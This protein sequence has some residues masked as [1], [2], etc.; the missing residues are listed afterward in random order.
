M[1]NYQKL[2]K[3]FVCVALQPFLDLSGRIC[4]MEWKTCD[5]RNGRWVHCYCF[6]A[7]QIAPSCRLWR[8]KL[9]LN[10]RVGEIVFRLYITSASLS[11]NEYNHIRRHYLFIKTLATYFDPTLGLLQA[12]GRQVIMCCVYIGFPIY[13]QHQWLSL[14]QAWE[15]H[16]VWVEIFS[17]F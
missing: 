8:S 3:I 5:K 6:A 14:P 4:A 17:L 16:N 15:W 11:Y 13:T 9:E 10:S 1:K 2:G 12:C 7:V